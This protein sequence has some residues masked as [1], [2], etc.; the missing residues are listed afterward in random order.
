M[1]SPVRPLL[2]RVLRTILPS[3]GRKW[4]LA[5]LQ[6]QQVNSLHAAMRGQGL[7]PLYERL[8]EIV[9][10]IRHQYTE[11]ELDSDYLALKVR[12]QHAF[13][14]LLAN[15]A[16]RALHNDKESLTLVDVGDSAGTH[17][18]YL[19]A[20]NKDINLRCVSVNLDEK[21]VQK[22]RKKGL[23]AVCARAEELAAQGVDADIILSFEM[24]EHLPNPID[25]LKRLS[26][27]SNC[28]AFALTVPYLTRSRVGLH[29]L[30][31]GIRR[32]S[33]PEMTHIFEL[34]PSDWSLL[35]MH[36]GWRVLKER[37]YLQYPRYGLYRIMKPV[38]KGLDFE[39]F[40]GAI[41]VRDHTWS[42]LYVERL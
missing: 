20:L 18:Q 28:K 16:I 17:V 4:L 41:L 42:D 31:H 14:V 33:T 23:E 39:G 5:A 21:A 27:N 2:E 40:W 24:L 13:Q 8:L 25:F 10:D 7:L 36:A 35:F 15:D 22:I 19:Q 29:Q 12:G 34:C 6:Q 1:T 3:G 38:W 11:E 30:R 9:P 26:E 32:R 37:L